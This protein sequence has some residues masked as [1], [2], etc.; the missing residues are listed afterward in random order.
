MGLMVMENIGEID[1]A[2]SGQAGDDIFIFFSCYSFIF[3]NTLSPP[4]SAKAD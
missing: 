2:L 3:L 4:C 1:E